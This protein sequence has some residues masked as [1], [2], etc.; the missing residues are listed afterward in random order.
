ME[1]FNWR[2]ERSGIWQGSCLA[3]KHWATCHWHLFNTKKYLFAKEN[4]LFDTR[5]KLFIKKKEEAALILFNRQQQSFISAE[6]TIIYL[7]E[8]NIHF[9]NCNE[10]R[11]TV[12]QMQHEW[13]HFIVLAFPI[14]KTFFN[15]LQEDQERDRKRYPIF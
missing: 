3:G 6:E 2:H 14:T 15:R 10:T 4:H 12:Q 9:R 13:I 5:S 7:R 8:W 11:W 1:Y